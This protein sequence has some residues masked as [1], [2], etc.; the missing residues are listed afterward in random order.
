MRR[1]SIGMTRGLWRAADRYIES[2]WK[3]ILEV[4]VQGDLASRDAHGGW[5]LMAVQ[6]IRLR[7]RAKHW[8]VRD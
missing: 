6:T 4:W 3:V 1:P 8:A 2:Y 7:L 5:Y